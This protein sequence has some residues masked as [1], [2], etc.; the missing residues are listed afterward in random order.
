[1]VSCVV[2]PLVGR[3]RDDREVAGLVLAGLGDAATPSNSFRPSVTA[4][5][6]R[7]CSA[8]GRFGASTTTVSGP[9]KPGPKPSSSR[10]YAWRVVA[11]AGSEPASGRPELHVRAGTAIAPSMPTVSAT[12]PRARRD[13]L[14]LADAHRVRALG[15]TPR[16]PVSAVPRGRRGPAKAKIAGSSVSA[17]STA[18]DTVPAAAM[19]ITVRNG[20]LTT[21]RPTSAMTTV[22]PANTTALP[23][24]AVACAAASRPSMPSCRLSGSG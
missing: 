15:T 9:L 18:S 6:T 11:S 24:V 7:A 12:A 5:A 2:G 10:S 21:S 1:M 22:A 14:R 3:D 23:A 8:A 4:P 20:M 13:E 17:I 19:P 16:T